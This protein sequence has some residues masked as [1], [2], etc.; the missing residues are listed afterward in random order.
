MGN[1]VKHFICPN[2][3]WRNPGLTIYLFS[4][5]TNEKTASCHRTDHH[6]FDSTTFNFH[7]TANKIQDRQRM[8]EGKWPLRGCEYCR[9][10]EQA[11]GQSDRITNL[12]FPGMYA[13]PELDF[14]LAATTV[15]PRI[16]EV[17]F[18]N[19]CNLKCLY[20]GPHFSSLWDAE[21]VKH[22]VPAFR[23]SKNLENNKQ[24]LLS[25][26]LPSANHCIN[27]T[28]EKVKSYLPTYVPTYIHL[29][30]Q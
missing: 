4:I 8:L 15:T 13:P 24:K 30:F 12:D 22:G 9:N 1:Y 26:A 18:D 14:D 11:G 23:K 27:L 25:S 20:C 5:L 2:R 29:P 6:T 7:N 28:L 16:L 19:V 10:I 3:I 21:N 17:Y